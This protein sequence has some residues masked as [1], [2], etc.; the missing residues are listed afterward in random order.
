[1][2]RFI[3]GTLFALS[4]GLAI[5]CGTAD[6]GS[7]DFDEV[8][9]TQVAPEETLDVFEQEELDGDIDSKFA[10]PPPPPSCPV[11]LDCRNNPPAGQGWL[12]QS[13][14][15]C[16]SYITCNWSRF[17][18]TP[19]FTITYLTTPSACPVCLQ[20]DGTTNACGTPD[21]PTTWVCSAQ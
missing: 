11:T 4:I 20:S 3:T 21:E 6:D 17:Y 9:I 1:M 10:K 16:T 14:D 8:G 18:P 7:L 12:L 13:T 5:G 19:G 2:N 15:F